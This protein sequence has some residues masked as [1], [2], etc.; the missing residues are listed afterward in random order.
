MY[1]FST[2]VLDYIYKS[3]HSVQND[4][5]KEVIIQNNFIINYLLFI[6]LNLHIKNFII[7]IRSLLFIYH[8]TSNHSIFILLRVNFSL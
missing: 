4:I 8:L 6:F 5:L 2:I 7:T 3:Y 1:L